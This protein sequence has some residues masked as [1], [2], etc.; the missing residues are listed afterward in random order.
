M[1]FA[2]GELHIAPLGDFHGIFKGRVLVGE[3][4]PQLVLGF[5]VELVGLELETVGVVHGLAHLDAHQHILGPAV[6]SAEVVGVVGDHQGQ[7]GLPGDAGNAQVHLPLLGEPVVLE[8]QVE[9]VGTEDLRELQGGGL[10]PVVVLVQQQLGNLARQ[11][12]RE[13][14]QPL[15]VLPQKRQI[16]PGLP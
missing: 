10:G 4:R 1:V 14:D 9:A 6:G 2:E 13:G 3:E 16:H 5:D 12:G 15:M 8:L 7:A 11:T